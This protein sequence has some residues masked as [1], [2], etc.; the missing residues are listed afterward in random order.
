MPVSAPPFR[1]KRERFACE[2]PSQ[3]STVALIERGCPSPSSVRL[4]CQMPNHTWTS[5][6]TSIQ[7]NETK[8]QQKPPR[9]K[10]P[11]K[12][13][14]PPRA[15]ER[16]HI[17]KYASLSFISASVLQGCA[18]PGRKEFGFLSP[19][20][21]VNPADGRGGTSAP[22]RILLS[23]AVTAHT[24]PQ[25]EAG[26]HVCRIIVPQEGIG[27]WHK[28]LTNPASSPSAVL[29]PCAAPDQSCNLLTQEF[30]WLMKGM[31]SSCLMLASSK[32]SIKVRAG[33]IHLALLSHLQPTLEFPGAVREAGEA[34][35]SESMRWPSTERAACLSRPLRGGRIAFHRSRL[36]RGTFTLF[37]FPFLS[38]NCSLPWERRPSPPTAL[39]VQTHT[40]A[41]ETLS[42]WHYA[43][44]G[45]A[46]VVP[47]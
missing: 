38:L 18:G 8:D 47:A 42:L 21:A 11:N 7:K 36:R 43:A 45:T 14:D 31:W 9:T 41:S 15:E 5:Q 6:N 28:S 4:M 10:P 17:P 32:R 19:S 29:I 30:G 39:G 44:H 46:G 12:T 16:R 3:G 13:L 27:V 33:S 34:A 40:L 23:L 24:H 26:I 20:F 37:K 22:T 2:V 25:P 35:R 1:P